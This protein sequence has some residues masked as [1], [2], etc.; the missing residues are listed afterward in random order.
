MGVSG[1]GKGASLTSRNPVNHRGWAGWREGRD[2][3]QGKGQAT[4]QFTSKFKEIRMKIQ[5]DFKRLQDPALHHVAIAPLWEVN[6]ARLQQDLGD[7]N[8]GL[9]EEVRAARRGQLAAVD[10]TSNKAMRVELSSGQAT[11]FVTNVLDLGAGNDGM[12]A[13]CA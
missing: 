5:A 13:A 12:W 3:D 2:A 4:V 9:T 8:A 1:T 7:P 6:T 10:A 11:V